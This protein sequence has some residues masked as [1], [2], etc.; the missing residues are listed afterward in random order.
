MS[1]GRGPF[2]DQQ[3]LGEVGGDR[4]RRSRAQLCALAMC[5]HDVVLFRGRAVDDE[6]GPGAGVRG[7]VL[8]PVQV[9]GFRGD[10][11]ELELF[12]RGGGGGGGEVQRDLEV[13]LVGERD[14]ER[15]LGERVDAAGHGGHLAGERGIH[16]VRGIGRAV[17]R[18]DV[19]RVLRVAAFFTRRLGV[20]ACEVAAMRR[21]GRAEGRGESRGG[22]RSAVGVGDI[23]STMRSPPL[24]SRRRRLSAAPRGDGD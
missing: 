22:G 23:S 13:A 8:W 5:R 12:V 6:E 11:C 7:G 1:D 14:V 24:R 15:A 2:V 4:I 16:L 9:S 21:R 17:V 10:G 18:A 3:P 20:R 19:A